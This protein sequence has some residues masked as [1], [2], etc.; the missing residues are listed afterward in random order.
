[1]KR[2]HSVCAIIMIVAIV[3]LI[4]SCSN[5]PTLENKLEETGYVSFGN[6]GSRSLSVMYEMEDFDDLYWTYTAKKADGYG[7][8]GQTTSEQPVP[9]KTDGKGIGDGTVG[10]FSM[11]D[12]DFNLF[13]YKDAEKTI[14][15]YE[16]KTPSRVNIIAGDTKNVSVA[17]SPFGT[18]GVLNIENAYFHWDSTSG[19]ALPVINL[20][21]DMDKS[22][23]TVDK[24]FD[25]TPVVNENGDIT[26]ALNQT[27]P[28]GFYY[29]ELKATID[30]AS[31]PIYETEEFTLRIYGATTTTIYGDITEQTGPSVRFS[32]TKS[33]NSVLTTITGTDVR[34][35]TVNTTPIGS[36][37][38][39]VNFGTYNI[40]TSETTSVDGKTT[41]ISHVLEVAVSSSDTVNTS[42]TNR[43]IVEDG[44]NAVAA[45]DLNLIKTT[46][47]TDA[48]GKTT[49]TEPVTTF[50][51][52]EVT[53]TT[54]V[55]KNLF[56]VKVRYNNGTETP[57]EIT[58]D[59]YVPSTGM[60]VFKVSHFSE[61]YVT[62]KLP[63]AKIGSTYY[64]TLGEAITNADNGYTVNIN[65]L[66]NGTLD[67]DIA[68]GDGK[69]RNINFIGT[70]RTQTVDVITNTVNAEGGQLNYQRG[71][72]FTFENLTIKAGEGSFDGIVCDELTFKNC[73]ITGKLTLFGKA[74]FTNC[75]FEN[76]MVNQY[77]IWT[78]GGTDVTFEGCTFNTNGK[79]I[80]L[81]GGASGSN[82]TNLVVENCIFNDRNSGSAGKAAIEIG[83]DYNATYNLTVNNATVNGFAL[84]L[85][86]NSTLWANKNS[87]NSEHLTVTI[88][89][90]KMVIDVNSLKEA[91]KNGTSYIILG[92]NIDLTGAGGSEQINCLND[93][94]LDLNGNTING[95]IWSGSYLST[96]DGTRLTLIDSKSGGQIYS[97]F[98]FGEGG[99]M[100]QANAVTAWQHAVTINSGKYVSNNVA[101]V[102]QVQNTDAAEG[103]II[104]GG[105][106]G[107]T[108]D[109]IEG[110]SLPG[111]VG[112]C[113]SAVIGTVTINGG[114]FIAA[115]Y[116]S[117]IKAK[118]GSSNVDT[119]VNINGGYFKG[120]CMFDFGEDHSSPTIVNVYGGTFELTNPEEREDLST[121]F[122]YDNYTHA[123]LVNN[124][125]FKLN[126]MGGTFNYDPSSYVASGYQVVD[127]NNGTWTVK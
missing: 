78:W 75:T 125:M 71:S 51:G 70:N 111:P 80:L 11:G 64:E 108:T 124:D 33:D 87:M 62:A 122:A 115:T 67:N 31:T 59:S 53:I 56:D 104:N 65:V 118:S 14:K 28:V 116:G 92:G 12:W 120:A 63:E 58:P 74:T 98:R 114:T 83:N 16:G 13:A 24:S 93:L 17:V 6:A 52:N 26:F 18:T 44:K 100:M 72:S 97:K 107:G 73:T 38:T 123:A 99:A 10:P 20:T 60:L 57:E 89:G 66:E 49:T 42:D 22:D 109:L 119:V 36:D 4:L 5:N 23:E 45:L 112:G 103:V 29:C 30:T 81:Y 79:A 3:G 19:G 82:P 32:A 47:V 35:V 21:M 86:T 1:M 61:Y 96:A 9:P 102:C 76:T 8:T 94:T 50:E 84:G 110:V 113:V 90:N 15:V 7:Q 54:Y 68:N 117:V 43:F 88:D 40:G 27:I 39:K 95:S 126:I 91:V 77:S 41:K 69:S 127:N 25:I 34:E 37:T 46:E 2:K 101:V 85:N 55:A 105:Y 121:S 48:T 106:F